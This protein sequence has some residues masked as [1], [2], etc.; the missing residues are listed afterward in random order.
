MCKVL[1]KSYRGLKSVCICFFKRDR[2][3]RFH[4]KAIQLSGNTFEY[5]L[6]KFYF[7]CSKKRLVTYTDSLKLKVIS[8]LCWNSTITRITYI[9]IP[10]FSL[11]C[12]CKSPH[13]CIISHLYY[14]KHIMY[15]IIT[16]LVDK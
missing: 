9:S 16:F 8:F 15:K 11:F 12:M 1:K 5:I 14:G 2:I 6:L 3:K 10:S 7:T 13:S 4:F